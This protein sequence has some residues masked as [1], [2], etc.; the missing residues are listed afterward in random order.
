M[1]L[2]N[3]NSSCLGHINNGLAGYAIQ[4]AVWSWSMQSAISHQKKTFAP[5]ASAI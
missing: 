4:K 5:V 2:N 1:A 3:L